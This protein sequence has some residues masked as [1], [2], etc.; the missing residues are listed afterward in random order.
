MS[1]ISKLYN[2]YIN[3]VQFK[4]QF[5]L[6]INKRQNVIKQTGFKLMLCLTFIRFKVTFFVV[7]KQSR[8]E[9]IRFR[10]RMLLDIFLP[11]TFLRI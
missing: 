5:S 8:D 10:R 1:K 3:F 7:Q 2:L 6:L 9:L 4:F 11:L